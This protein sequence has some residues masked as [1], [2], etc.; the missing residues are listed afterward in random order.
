MSEEMSCGQGPHQP[1]STSVVLGKL[2]QFFKAHSPRVPHIPSV[3][4]GMRVSTSQGC[5]KELLKF[6]T[7]KYQVQN[8]FSF[9]PSPLFLPFYF[10]IFHFQVYV[11]FGG[12]VTPMAQ[13]APLDQQGHLYANRDCQCVLP[14]SPKPHHWQSGR[15]GLQGPGDSLGL[16]CHPSPG[17]REIWVAYG[18]METRLSQG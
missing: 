13:K 5:P 12:H 15:D 11:S 6:D 7:A 17:Q 9:L 14:P 1:T 16:R 18:H 2:S 4:V 8:L 10:P 3:K